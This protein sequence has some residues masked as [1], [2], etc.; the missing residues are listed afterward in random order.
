MQDRASGRPIHG[1]DVYNRGVDRRDTRG[2]PTRE[3]GP[4][5]AAAIHRLLVEHAADVLV[6]TVAGVVRWVS[7]EIE[8]LSGW[9]PDELVGA[10]AD[11]VWHPDDLAAVTALRDRGASG[12][13]CRGVFRLRHRDGGDRWVELSQRPCR[14]TDGQ[15]GA[16][17]T[18]R[19]V[20][21]AIEAEG[22]RAGE[23][24]E[25]ADA[26][27]RLRLTVDSSAIGQCLV[28]P[29]GGFLQVNPALCR[30]LGR[31]PADLLRCTWQD[32]TDPRDVDVDQHLVDDVLAGR[33]D[34]YRLRKR[35]LR[36]D[37][38]L[39]WG[40]L[41]VSCVRDPDGSVRYFISQVVDVT[42]QVQARHALEDSE[43]RLRMLVENSADVVFRCTADGVLEW[44]S[45]SVAVNLGWRPEELVGQPFIDLVHPEDTAAVRFS[46]RRL[47][48][49][50][51]DSLEARVRT[52]SGTFRWMSITSA[53]LHGPAGEV[54][55]R[56]G[57][58]RD[59]EAE[60]RARA[61]LREE[62]QRYRQLAENATDVVVRVGPDRRVVWVAPSVTESL[63]WRPDDLV[64]TQLTELI[65]PEDAE[66]TRVVRG[67]VLAPR[68][69][70]AGELVMRLRNRRGEYR[71]FSARATPVPL[72]GGSGGGAVVGFR[73]VDRLV[74]AERAAEEGR[75]RMKAALDA[76]FDPHVVL[77][78]VRDPAGQVVD[79]VYVEANA[80]A[81]A[82]SGIGYREQIGSRLLE[83]ESA[84]D[85][86]WLL[87]ACRRV[88]ETGEPLSLN[89]VTFG[90]AAA[91]PDGRRYDIRAVRFADHGL[92]YTWRDVTERYR[93]ARQAE[94]TAE[95]YRMLAENAS[96]VVLMAGP[97]RRV[98]WVAPSV[99][100][101]LGWTPDELVGT[102]LADLLG[103]GHARVE[104]ARVE[105]GRGTLADGGDAA[106]GPGA[107]QLYSMR[108]TA[109]ERRWM[110]GPV[111]PVAGPNG[112]P[113]GVVVGLR[114]VTEAVGTRHRLTAVLDA[115]P[116][117]YVLL[118]A[119]RD[120]T[121]GVVDFR[122]DLANRVARE[123]LGRTPSDRVGA[124][125]P[126]GS[127]LGPELVAALATVLATGQPLVL[128]GRCDPASMDRADAWADLRAVR[129][130]DGVGVSWQSCRTALALGPPRRPGGP[131]HP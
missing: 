55:G 37:G 40:D 39:V 68:S 53:P 110:S 32:L 46:Q 25:L 103:P 41:S 73:D 117:P 15:A 106:H 35:Y 80:A 56:T 21:A 31:E 121:G 87:E 120:R 42:E 16:V 63:G 130:D 77:E 11:V 9:S 72:G 2:G 14:T 71:W 104:G 91:R 108:T 112:T 34:S 98:Q 61:A 60:V 65:H 22:V 50:R 38:G 85:G 82:A 75:A 70:G 113:L 69:T 83:R 109:G 12:E 78:P 51:R 92:S 116:H 24:A 114:D 62:E 13:T 7:P 17:G 88:L 19:D 94:L 43:A 79:F 97:D 127:P 81:C 28:A 5:T 107:D 3:T 86:A 49:G 18:L 131:G 124:M 36:P 119:M 74:R 102:R 125:V 128:D 84:E 20:T 1:P 4:D 67:L 23:R 27:E 64:G 57:A 115:M 58:W 126:G 93:A 95:R 44:L 123:A 6:H 101:V 111:R 89:D 29:D 54:I 45:P 100:A 47:G 33:R 26:V 122:V 48:R 76:Q 59:I 105:G 90:D 52:R 30:I 8:D 99:T 10:P 129:V 66:A 96:D 118:R